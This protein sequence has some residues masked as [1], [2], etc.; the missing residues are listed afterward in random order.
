M[1]NNP[2]AWAIIGLLFTLVVSKMS[3]DVGYRAGY[4]A[5][6]PDVSDPFPPSAGESE[7]SKTCDLLI[8]KVGELL[9]LEA[10]QDAEARHEAAGPD[11]R[12]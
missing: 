7:R 2:V 3:H 12:H 6:P 10:M 11:A 8:A 1:S 9:A 4:M 5:S